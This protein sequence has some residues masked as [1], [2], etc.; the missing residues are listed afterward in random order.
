MLPQSIPK[1]MGGQQPGRHRLFGPLPGGRPEFGA[2]IRTTE[3]LR[4][5]TSPRLKIRL[6]PQGEHETGFRVLNA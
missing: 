1:I 3:P 6:A 2:M 4:R 5:T